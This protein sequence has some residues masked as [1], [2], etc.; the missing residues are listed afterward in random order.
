MCSASSLDLGL[1]MISLSGGNSALL[2][3]FGEERARLSE[4]SMF[5][6]IRRNIQSCCRSLFSQQLLPPRLYPLFQTSSP[7]PPFFLSLSI[8]PLRGGWLTSLC[9]SLPESFLFLAFLRW[10]A[11]P[12]Q[13]F[14]AAWE[15]C[16][17]NNNLTG[18]A[19]S[20]RIPLKRLFL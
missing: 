5:G 19:R 14:I 11:D 8:F 13:S 1:G 7:F 2:S 18:E 6:P 12:F 4:P 15:R 3:Y 17:T 20:R 10:P 9:L 16:K